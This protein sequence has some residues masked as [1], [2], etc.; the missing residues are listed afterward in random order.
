MQLYWSHCR[1]LLPATRSES[2]IVR[3]AS[4]PGGYGLIGGW[5]AL[6]AGVD[7]VVNA[8]EALPDAYHRR[9]R[10][11]F[12]IGFPAFTAVLGLV[13]LMLTRPAF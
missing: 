11:R 9:Y 4:V 10:R 12:A 6:L 8:Q 5:R 1:Q 7:V 3:R 13:R 2:D